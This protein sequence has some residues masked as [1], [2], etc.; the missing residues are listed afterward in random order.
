MMRLP[1]IASAAVAGLVLVAV[2]G[3]ATSASTGDTQFVAA[4]T[5]YVAG[6]PPEAT[7][8]VALDRRE[9]LF[10]GSWTSPCW[11]ICE[12]EA[13]VV[14]QESSTESR[15]AGER[16]LRALR[17]E[18]EQARRDYSL[19]NRLVRASDQLQQERLRAVPEQSLP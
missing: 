9:A 14:V 10:V 7:N 16:R 17:D 1:A 19:E 12:P 4:V 8:A 2:A 13:P 18:L 11:P 3:C 6:A 15:L 5:D